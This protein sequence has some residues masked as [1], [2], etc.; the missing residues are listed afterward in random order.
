MAVFYANNKRYET[1]TIVQPKC[2]TSEDTVEKEPMP[3]LYPCALTTTV[4]EIPVFTALDIKGLKSIG[5]SLRKI[6]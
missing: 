2:T 6:C 3:Q 4:L 1:L 5:A